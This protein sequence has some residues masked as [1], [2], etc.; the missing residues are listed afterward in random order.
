V[1]VGYVTGGFGLLLALPP[2][3]ALRSLGERA[4]V[5][6]GRR[7]GKRSPCAAQGLP[8]VASVDTLARQPT[9]VS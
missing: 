1:A 2:L 7:A 9:P 5:I 3:I 8:E 4:D 6:V